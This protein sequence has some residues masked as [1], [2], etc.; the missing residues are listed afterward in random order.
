MHVPCSWIEFPAVAQSVQI[1]WIEETVGCVGSLQHAD[2][3]G[4]VGRPSR[5][6]L[7]AGVR[8]PPDTVAERGEWQHGWQY[9]ASSSLEHHFLET[10]VVAPSSVANQAHLRS[11]SGPGA[12][13]LV[14]GA[15]TGPEFTL[16]PGVF[17]TLVLERLRLP[18]QITESHCEVRGA[19]RPAGPPQGSLPQVREV[20][21]TSG[22]ARE[23][24]STDLS[25][26][27]GR[28]ANQRDVEGHE[29][30]CVGS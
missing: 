4:F 27:G 9:C 30:H 23:D 2:R 24:L 19:S 18:L 25:R 1:N 12:S 10:V 22:G 28:G 11:H 26:G 8:P 13:A 21:F 6:Q 14:C 16:Q 3:S 5:E 20:A 29:H 15:P 7:R 17:R